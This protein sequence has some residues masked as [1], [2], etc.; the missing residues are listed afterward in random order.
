MANVMKVK[1]RRENRYGSKGPK[2]T[3]RVRDTWIHYRNDERNLNGAHVT[4][5]AGPLM[6][7]LATR[8]S[9]TCAR[10]CREHARGVPCRRFHKD[11]ATY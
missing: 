1:E 10:L 6:A 11:G 9:G 5:D 3:G 7:T 8:A 2:E 4:A